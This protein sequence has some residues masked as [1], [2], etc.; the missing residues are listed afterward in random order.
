MAEHEQ[1]GQCRSQG[2]A[3]RR[4]Y[5]RREMSCEIGMHGSNGDRKSGGRSRRGRHMKR[6][7]DLVLSGE[8]WL[9]LEPGR[10]RRLRLPKMHHSTVA[11][12]APLIEE[13]VRGGCLAR[14][15]LA[16]R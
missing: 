6:L 13:V 1:V 3:H 4:G 14:T 2:L 9:W 11:S 5:A 12:T 16:S 8:L 15:P 7:H 10:G